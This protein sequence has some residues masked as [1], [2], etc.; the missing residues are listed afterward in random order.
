VD[1]LFRRRAGQMISTLT[2]IFGPRHLDLVEEVVQEAFLKALRQWPYHGVPE[3]PS[4][5]LIQVA[6]NRALDVLRRRAS[7]ERKRSELERSVFRRPEAWADDQAAFANE[8]RDDELRMVFT[9]CDGA[10]SR[11]AQVALTLKTVGG[12]STSEIARAFL[13]RETTVAQRLV[14]AKRRLRERGIG[15]AVPE[16]GGLTER[17]DTVHEVL[18]L[19]FNEGYSSSAG[20]SLIR[21]DLCRQAIRLAELVCDHP[22]TGTPQG[23]ALAALFLFQA[24]RQAARTDPAGNVVLLEDQDRTLWDRGVLRRALSHFERSAAG[25]LLGRYH[26]EAEIASCH[27]LAESFAATD[28]RR[29]LAAYDTLLEFHPSPVAA[30]NRAVAVAWV[31]GEEAALAELECLT[32]AETLIVYPPFHAARGDLLQRLGRSA[33]AAVAY[34]R[35]IELTTSVPVRRCL[36]GKLARVG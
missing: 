30:L 10:L 26:L 4:A 31:D 21:D 6:K 8:L 36:V 5:W 7:W 19:I 23:H 33:E 3:N 15:F 12:L 24:C 1:H 22:R 11:D 29:I 16:P 35:A 28:W 32:G 20:E 13:T 9:C 25:S 14:R 17:I 27:A 18:Y 34:R 2:R